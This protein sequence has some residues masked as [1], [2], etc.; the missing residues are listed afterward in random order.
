MPGAALPCNGCH[1]TAHKTSPGRAALTNP[2]NPGA[3]ATG[4]AFPNPNPAIALTNVGATMAQTL[5]L[6]TCTNGQT[7]SGATTP[8]SQLLTA[9]VVYDGIWTVGTT[10]PQPDA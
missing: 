10:P 8:C 5:A 2:V 9:D 4:S 1:T 6:T 3:P 7:P